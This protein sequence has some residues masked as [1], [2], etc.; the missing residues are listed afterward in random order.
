[1]TDEPKLMTNAELMHILNNKVKRDIDLTPI[2]YYVYRHHE[3]EASKP[4]FRRR[5]LLALRDYLNTINITKE[6][7]VMVANYPPTSL[8]DLYVLLNNPDEVFGSEEEMISF[9]SRISDIMQIELSD[10]E[11]EYKH[12]KRAKRTKGKKNQRKMH[13]ET[14]QEEENNE[15][16]KAHDLNEEEEDAEGFVDDQRELMSDEEGGDDSE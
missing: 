5:R 9:I 15:D 14:K 12:S 2:E 16:V 11:E 10:D 1:M 3:N 7:K 4:L 8:V 13:E 6:E